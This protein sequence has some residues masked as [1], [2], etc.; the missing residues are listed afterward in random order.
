MTSALPGLPPEIWL[1]E[2]C[3]EY[4]YVG[5]PLQEAFKARHSEC[6]QSGWQ[7][8]GARKAFKGRVCEA[9]NLSDTM[10]GLGL[11]LSE[12]KDVK[13][14]FSVEPRKWP[15]Q[16]S[17]RGAVTFYYCE[18]CQVHLPAESP[19]IVWFMREHRDC[20]LPRGKDTEP[21]TYLTYAYTKKPNENYVLYEPG[22]MARLGV[23]GL[24]EEE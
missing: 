24:E 21:Y 20:R 19:F 17:V 4:V 11:A 16:S 13:R 1:C 2:H 15:Y 8:V 23:V 6:Y 14:V 22:P 9:S 3:K 18:I 12:P 10:E 5:E 7:T